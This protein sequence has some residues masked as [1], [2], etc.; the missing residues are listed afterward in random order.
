MLGDKPE[1]SPSGAKAR[2][3]IARFTYGLKPVPSIGFICAGLSPLR[4]SIDGMISIKH[5]VDDS[6]CSIVSF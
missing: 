5:T 6:L 1:K 3:D 4:E 2:V